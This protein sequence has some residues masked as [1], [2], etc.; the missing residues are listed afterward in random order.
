MGGTASEGDILEEQKMS[1]KHKSKKD[2]EANGKYGRFENEPIDD[3]PVDESNDIHGRTSS[4]SATP[5]RIL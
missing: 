1:R 3:R 5:D 4:S 2:L